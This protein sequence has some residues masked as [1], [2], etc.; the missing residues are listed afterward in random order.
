MPVHLPGTDQNRTHASGDAEQSAPAWRTEPAAP[1]PASPRPDLALARDCEHCRGWGT[2]ITRDGD[3][4]LCA[5]RQPV[6]GAADPRQQ[7][8]VHRRSPD[9]H[10]RAPSGPGG[11]PS[12]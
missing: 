11:A 7:V 12:G 1:R 2:V 10:P 4:L 3:H 9:R 8:P 6:A 5:V